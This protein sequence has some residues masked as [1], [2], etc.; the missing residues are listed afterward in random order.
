[1]NN[2]LIFLIVVHLFTA[3]HGTWH[4]SFKHKSYFSMLAGF[5]LYL[6]FGS[7]VLVLALI[8]WANYM[9]NRYPNEA[10]D[11][12]RHNVVVRTH[13]FDFYK[14]NGVNMFFIEADTPTPGDVVEIVEAAA[15]GKNARSI[16]FTIRDVLD[17]DYTESEVLG[18]DPEQARFSGRYLV[19]C[20]KQHII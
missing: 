6:V 10:N 8:G 5:I 1:M 20:D 13:L 15:G 3:F 16:R 14:Q 19:V 7:L 18:V 12:S 4:N 9:L 11:T 17:N 2:W